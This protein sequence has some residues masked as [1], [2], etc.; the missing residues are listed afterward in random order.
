MTAFKTTPLRR[1]RPLAALLA[2][3]VLAGCAA[4]APTPQTPEQIVEA[5]AN[6][7]WA[8]MLKKD[9]PTAYGYL[10]PG[11]RS[12]FPQDA[13]AGSRG[14]AVRWK[15]AEVSRVR[16]PSATKCLAT[17]RIESKSLVG[18]GA[19]STVPTYFDETWVLQDGQWWLYINV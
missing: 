17:V 12:I 16:C 13:F 6:A 19:G 11:V 1:A 3:A 14:S 10:A 2:A 18:R 7:Y 15:A 9:V 4:L 5:R 8:A